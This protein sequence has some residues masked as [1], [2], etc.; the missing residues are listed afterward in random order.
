MR[1]KI[2][3]IFLKDIEKSSLIKSM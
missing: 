2:Y 3:D 1:G